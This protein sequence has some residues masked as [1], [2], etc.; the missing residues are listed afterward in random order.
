MGLFGQKVHTPFSDDPQTDNDNAVLKI[1]GVYWR[2][3]LAEE[4]RAR[5]IR[6][7]REKHVNAPPIDV[8]E[9]LGMVMTAFVMIVIRRDRPGRMG[10]AVLIRGDSSSGVQ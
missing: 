6:C 1:K 8:L 2:Y 9:L 5:T 10:E 3:S 7:R 4:W